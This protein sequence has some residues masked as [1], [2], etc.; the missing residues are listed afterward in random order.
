VGR[1]ADVHLPG[2]DSGFVSGTNPE[3]GQEVG[4]SR[5][6]GLLKKER[7]QP[8]AELIDSIKA[9]VSSFTGAAAAADDIT[10]VVARL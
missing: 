2:A 1:V 9:E 4:E 6:I 10:I 8:S 7:H 3:S 5:L